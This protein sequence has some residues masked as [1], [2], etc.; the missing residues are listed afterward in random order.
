M[1]NNTSCSI[2]QILQQ[3][4]FSLA[5]QEIVDALSIDASA[6]SRIKSGERGLKFDEIA[7][8]LSLRSNAFHDGLDVIAK[9]GGMYV[10]KDELIALRSL[11]LKY[12]TADVSHE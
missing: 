2:A 5:P 12:L 4:L 11:A 6:V 9:D 7:V 1:S 3:H 10:S 8:L